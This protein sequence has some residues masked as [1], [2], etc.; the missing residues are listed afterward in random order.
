MERRV[1]SIFQPHD[2]DKQKTYQGQKGSGRFQTPECEN[3]KKQPG[4]PFN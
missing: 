3:G 1:L 2:V 4:I